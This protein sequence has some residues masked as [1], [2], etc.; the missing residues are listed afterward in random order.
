[1]AQSDAERAL[2]WKGRK[3]AFAA[4]GRISPNY[5]VQDGVIPRTALPQ[6]MSEIDRLSK[7]AGIRVANVFHAGDGNLHP[8]V[9]YDRRI[10]GQEDAAEALSYRILEIC[11]AAGGSITGEHGVGEDKKMAMSKMFSEPDLETM[12]RVRCAFDPL[13]LSNPTKVF[14]RPRLCG[15]KPG[16]YVPHPLETAGIAER[17]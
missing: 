17:F 4:M 2:V 5:I 14:P 8:L 13:Q 16:K 10:A 7:E 9:L 12:Q 15:E 11:I 3:A 6:V 1:M